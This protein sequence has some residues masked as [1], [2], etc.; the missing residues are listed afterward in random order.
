MSYT[1]DYV[2]DQARAEAA[3]LP[4]EGVVALLELMAAVQLDPW[5]V[6]RADPGGPNMP[7]VPFGASGMVSLLIL[8]DSREVL[9]TKVQWAG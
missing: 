1:W 6:A 8:D 3:A 9:I 7:P 5:G 4:I 2:N